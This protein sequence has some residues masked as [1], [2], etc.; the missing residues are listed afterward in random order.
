MRRN[1]SD[2]TRKVR[3]LSILFFVL[4]TICYFGVA[5]FALI[6]CFSTIM[7]R[8]TTGVDIISQS[9]KAKLASFSVT[10]VVG[11]IL[12]L[13][14]KEKMRLTIYMLSLVILS[15]IYKEAGMYTVLGIWAF[16]E[17]VF[18]A[19]HKHYHKLKVINKEIDLRE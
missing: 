13:I 8:N 12:A 19:L 4:S 11:L 18:S 17:Y 6:T 3:N 16:D 15:I 14:I 10:M 1:I 9:L 5:L 2:R 7:G